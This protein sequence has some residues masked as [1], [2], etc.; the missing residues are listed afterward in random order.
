MVFPPNSMSTLRCSYGK[1][2]GRCSMR[3]L[4]LGPGIF[5]VNSGTT[6]LLWNVQV[7]FGCAGSRKVRV[8]VLVC[9][10]LP[11]NSRTEYHLV[12]VQVHFDCTGSRKVW[13]A[14]LACGILLVNSCTKGWWLLW[15]VQVHFDRS[16]APACFWHFSHKMAF[17][18]HPSA[19]RLRTLAQS[20]VRGLGLRHLPC[21][22]SHKVVLLQR[23]RAF[24]LRRLAQSA[25]RGLGLRHSTC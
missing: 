4:Y 10:I 3:V 23:P 13:V 21:R 7:H 24:R 14:V 16:W 15:N 6:W 9:G 19:F 11:V 17:V 5:S 1:S 25:D 20:V 22:F 12:N 18:K 2:K 8:A